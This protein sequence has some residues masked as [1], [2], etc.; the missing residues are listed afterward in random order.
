MAMASSRTG[1]RTPGR[2][3][4]FDLDD[5]LD[6]AI[7]T[8]RDRGY[9]GSSMADLE[10]ATGLNTSSIYNAF[11]SKQALFDQSLGRYEAVRLST[12]MDVLGAGTG[13]LDDLHRALEIQQFESVSEWGR[14]G[15]FAINTMV[16]LGS[17]AGD[18]TAVLADF[19]RRL[20]E[21]VRLPLERAV[22]LGEMNA[23]QVPN[24]AVLLVT[25]T[26][27]V[28][29][30]MRGAAPEAEIAAHFAAAHDLVDSWRIT[31]AR[32]SS[33]RSR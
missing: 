23:D 5:V 19:R 7:E 21:A 33:G 13:G 3:R 17:R 9:E 4:N 22:A 1:A 12:I 15:C 29:V 26:L 31:R 14:D 25:F 24:A 28:G 8:F 6:R 11:G 2:P 10:R 27:G 20:A 30:L 18:L 32:R 16:E